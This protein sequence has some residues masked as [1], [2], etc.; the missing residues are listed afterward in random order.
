M[1]GRYTDQIEPPQSIYTVVTQ[2]SIVNLGI[3][4]YIVWER[5]RLAKTDEK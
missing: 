5:N 2:K 1:D 4:I 3:N